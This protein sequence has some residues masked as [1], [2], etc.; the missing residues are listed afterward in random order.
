MRP[1]ASQS[2][3]MEANLAIIKRLR[4]EF[5]NVVIGAARGIKVEQLAQLYKEGV[6]FVGLGV[7]NAIAGAETRD[8]EVGGI[9]LSSANMNL[10]TRNS[11]GD[12]KFDIDP[13]MLQRLQ[14]TT[15]FV[16]VI[17]NVQPLRSLSGF[18]GLADLSLQESSLE[19]A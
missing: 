14:N 16:P 2:G 4:A 17:I 3:Q 12:I 18:L 6:D 15:G 19:A 1:F 5:P 8:R 9:D 11:G 10:Q 13:A 7:A